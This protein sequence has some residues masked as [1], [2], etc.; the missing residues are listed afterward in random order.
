MGWRRHCA[1]RLPQLPL[2]GPR[3]PP[4]QPGGRCRLRCCSRRRSRS[5][6]LIRPGRRL[7][8]VRCCSRRRS[9]CRP[10]CRPRQIRPRRPPPPAPCR[11]HRLI[12]SHPDQR[13]TSRTRESCP[14]ARETPG[15]ARQRNSAA[16]GSSQTAC[17]TPKAR[18]YVS[19]CPPRRSNPPTHLAVTPGPCD[20]C[21]GGRRLCLSRGPAGRVQKRRDAGRSVAVDSARFEL[22]LRKSFPL[23][24]GGGGG[25]GGARRTARARCV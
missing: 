15:A 23:K 9:R 16:Q 17:R 21:I 12:C 4:V 22:G 6:P 10:G 7:P 13:R 14:G 1:R 2:R 8:P 20:A 24:E 19:A 5:R 11:Q 18:E 25:G 3:C